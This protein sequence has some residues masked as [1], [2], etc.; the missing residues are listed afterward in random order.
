VIDAF[1]SM[2]HYADHLLP[3]MAALPDDRR[4]CLY[5][6]SQ[7]SREFPRGSAVLWDGV[8]V[9]VVVGRQ[10]PSGD[11]PLLVGG[12][13]DL[14]YSRRPK[15][16]VNH[17][18]GQTYAGADHPSYVGGPAHEAAD[19]FLVARPELAE[20]ELAHYPR[21]RAVS[22]GCPKLDA[23][24]KIPKPNN[25]NAVVAVTFHWDAHIGVPEAGS[26]WRTWRDT[27]A[28]LARRTGQVI[29]HAHPRAARE[30]APWWE[31][32]GVEYVA[33]PED[34]LRRCDCLVLDNSSLGFEWAALDRPTV[35][36][37]DASWD[38]HAEHGLRFGEELPGPRLAASYA[39]D[40]GELVDAINQSLRYFVLAR[41]AVARRVYQPLWGGSQVAA[42]AVL[43]LIDHPADGQSYAR[44]R[45]CGC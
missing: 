27:I 39:G 42:Q 22:V 40:V 20:I 35:W 19:L 15:V 3:I 21:A 36:L 41:A 43:D 18:A 33:D 45:D 44:V 16:L 38:P 25:M 23:W 7:L 9:S 11:D 31:S 32:I 2:A 10:A 37:D 12:Y 4:G 14:P 24:R 34:L 6:P 28:E 13:Q 30:L 17:G 8:P 1:C 26:A 5:V 29:G